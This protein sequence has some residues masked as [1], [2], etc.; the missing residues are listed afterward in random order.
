MQVPGPWYEAISASISWSRPT[1]PVANCCRTFD[2]S[3][4]V[5]PLV[6][7]PAGRNT[8]GRCPKVAAAITSPGTILSQTPR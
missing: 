6:I 3:S 5:M 7:G 2:F 4:L 8:A 1:S